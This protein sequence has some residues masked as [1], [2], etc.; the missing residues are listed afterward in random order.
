[1]DGVRAISHAAQA[2]EPL[3][4]EVEG[5]K[6]RPIRTAGEWLKLV[7]PSLIVAAVVGVV[8]GAWAYMS[9]SRAM[10]PPA[11]RAHPHHA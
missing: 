4:D 7:I 6:E 8:G 5:L 11:I 2:V 3:E 1:M 9:T 10:D